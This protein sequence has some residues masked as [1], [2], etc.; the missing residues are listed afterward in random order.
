MAENLSRRFNDSAPASRAKH[1]APF[2]LRLSDEERA[3][4]ERAAGSQPLGAY[5]RARVFGE[6]VTPRRPVR[7]PIQDAQALAR[8]LGALG[9]SRLA[10][11][12]NQIAKAANAGAL[13]VTPEL[14]DEL[15][16]ACR[17]VR[18]MRTALIAALGLKPE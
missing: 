15:A 10:S 4:L 12:L 18:E 9:Q 17:D 14:E 1:A 13:P 5:I 8:V 3:E 7:R 11:N 16:L 2:S 6:R